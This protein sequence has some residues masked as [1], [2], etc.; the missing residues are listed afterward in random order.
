MRVSGRCTHQLQ[1]S[2]LVL[3]LGQ[4]MEIAMGEWEEGEG[5][6]EGMSE[7]FHCP[8]YTS[9]LGEEV[10]GVEEVGVYTSQR[11]GKGVWGPL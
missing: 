10:E 11:E 3:P 8:W 2:S 4:M 7:P 9:V 6:G 1:G 5:E